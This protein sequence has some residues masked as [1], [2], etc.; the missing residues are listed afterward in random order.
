MALFSPLKE[1]I[2]MYRLDPSDADDLEEIIA[3]AEIY[4]QLEVCMKLLNAIKHFD[5]NIPKDLLEEAL[6]EKID[7]LELRLQPYL[8]D[9]AFNFILKKP[10]KTE[11]TWKIEAEKEPEKKEVKTIVIDFEKE[12]GK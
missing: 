9:I 3:K 4:A 12:G 2:R 11:L 10:V 1:I 7:E 8:E 5:K 6:N